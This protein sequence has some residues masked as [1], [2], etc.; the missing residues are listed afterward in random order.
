LLPGTGTWR[1]LGLAPRKLE[2]RAFWDFPAVFD[3]FREKQ[4]TLLWRGSRDGFG[5][6]DFH[7]R[8]DGHP[9]TLTV[10]LETDG[11]IFG[12][13]TPV[14]WES[15]AVGTW[16][17]DPS[18]KSFLFTLQN[19]HNVPAHRFALKAEMEGQA[20]CCAS[21]GGPD[22]LTLVCSIFATQAPTVSLRTL[23]SVTPTIPHWTGKRFTRVQWISK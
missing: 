8:C 7:S 13:F 16:K 9:N 4:F 12:G 22:F 2:S 10:I 3:E 5:A 17:A 20:I 18:L 14:E 6:F 1:N 15:S 23:T 11:N 21:E 19:P